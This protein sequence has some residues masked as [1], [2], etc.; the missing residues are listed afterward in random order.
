MSFGRKFTVLK[1]VL[2][3][4]L[5]LFGA[6]AVMR[7]SHNGIASPFPPVVTPLPGASRL[8]IKTIYWFSCFKAVRLAIRKTYRVLVTAFSI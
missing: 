8:N 3:K 4:L 5:G 1:K 6:P 2:V 7:R